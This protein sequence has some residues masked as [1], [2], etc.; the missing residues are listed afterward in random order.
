[1]LACAGNKHSM[2]L[3]LTGKVYTWGKG[4]RD[5]KTT[6]GEFFK[7]ENPFNHPK[8]KGLD[9][10][11]ENIASGSSHIGAIT[12]QGSLFMWGETEKDALVGPLRLKSKLCILL[13]N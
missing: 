5:T 9:L 10:F 6:I 4:I 12:S 11:F 13:S 1:V 7:P 8:F 3:T 2:C